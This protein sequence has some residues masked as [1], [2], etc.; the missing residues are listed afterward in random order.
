MTAIG[1]LHLIAT[2]GL[3]IALAGATLVEAGL[4]D[5]PTNGWGIDRPAPSGPTGR[6]GQAGGTFV[7][8]N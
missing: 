1:R 3:L 2:L 5:T 7:A 6:G 4:Y 8:G